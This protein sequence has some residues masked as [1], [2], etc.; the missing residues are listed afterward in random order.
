MLS[1]P[2]KGSWTLWNVTAGG[3]RPRRKSA[4]EGAGAEVEAEAE[5]EAGAAALP[6]GSWSGVLRLR[7]MPRFRMPIMLGGLCA[8]DAAGAFAPPPAA[9]PPPP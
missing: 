1:G 9:S 7:T 3:A 2:A 6:A 5:A 4:E 8:M